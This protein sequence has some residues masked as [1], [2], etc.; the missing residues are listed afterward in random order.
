MANESTKKKS[1]RDAN[2]TLQYAFNDVD[3]T[4]SINGFI[5]AKVGHKVTLEITTTLIGSDTE[6][7]RFFDDNAQLYEITLIY[8]DGSRGTLISAE[9]T[10]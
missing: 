9:R 4:L 2:Q 7:Y 6:I 5:A 3:N 8:T 10:A 1:N